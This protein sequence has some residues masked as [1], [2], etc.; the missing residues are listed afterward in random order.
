M[1]DVNE[2]I[3]R[4]F[5]ENND[6]LVK[7]NYPY[8]LNNVDSDIDLLVFNL[9]PAET[10]NKDIE[11]VIKDT[12]DLERITRASIEVKGWHGMNFT[13]SVLREFDRI[14][15]FVCENAMNASKGFWKTDDFKTILVLSH[16]PVKESAYNETIKILKEHKIDHV[17]EF[18]TIIDFMV[19]KV[20]KNKNYGD[21]EFLQT[22]R[23]LKIYN[24]HF[25]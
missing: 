4:L 1:S 5:F 25:E 11:F 13:P 14:F 19:S 17:I 21:S 15:N 7:T 2:E 6:F 3:V 8:K 20:E 23:I 24:E 10:K 22:I 16:L 12:K 18:K 9:Y